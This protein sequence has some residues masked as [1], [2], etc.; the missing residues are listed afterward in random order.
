[1][2]TSSSSTIPPA[3]GQ[4][5]TFNCP[6][7][8]HVL[9][10]RYSAPGL[11]SFQFAPAS[12]RIIVASRRTGPGQWTITAFNNSFSP[13]AA[14]L[15]GYA[16]CERNGKGRG[17]GEASGFAT[18]A[19]NGRTAADASCSAKQ[20]VVSGGF[21]VSPSSFPGV[22]PF[23]G[24]D[25]FQPLGKRAWHVGLHEFPQFALPPGSS[26]QTFAYCKQQPKAKKKRKRK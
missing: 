24:L 19:D 11:G 5:M 26:L 8:T 2:Q 16:V 13:A 22:V 25:E 14:T 17:V 23:V 4:N 12:A 7:G 3:A 21:L 20:H 18:I 1:M 10:G 15:T 9:T 6:P